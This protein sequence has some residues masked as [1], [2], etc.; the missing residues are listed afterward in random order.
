MILKEGEVWVSEKAEGVIDTMNSKPVSVG[1]TT[2]DASEA[3][4]GLPGPSTAGG[5]SGELAALRFGGCLFCVP[6]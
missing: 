4:P 3:R 6:T 1:I 5:T 2:D